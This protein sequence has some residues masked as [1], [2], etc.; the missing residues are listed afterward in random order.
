MR[1]NPE[2][3]RQIAVGIQHSSFKR[4]E[5]DEGSPMDEDRNL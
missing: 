4:D 5:G 2:S 1:F 3:C